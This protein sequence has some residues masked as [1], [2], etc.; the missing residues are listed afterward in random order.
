MIKQEVGQVMACEPN[1]FDNFDEF[2]LFELSQIMNE[3]D[4]LVVLV[5]HD[6]FI[7][8]DS[9]SLKEKIVIDTRGIWR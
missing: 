3:A 1:V 4:I 5:D 8:I 2:P 6:E 7:D 9:E